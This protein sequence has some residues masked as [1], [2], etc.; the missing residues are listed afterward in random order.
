MGTADL[1]VC[2]CLCVKQTDK[3]TRGVCVHSV[4]SFN[5]CTCEYKT[6]KDRGQLALNSSVCVHAHTSV[7]ALYAS[8]HKK[9]CLLASWCPC[10]SP[11]LC[12]LCVCM[13]HTHVMTSEVEKSSV[14]SRP[15]RQSA[16]FLWRW[17]I[18]PPQLS[19]QRHMQ[20]KRPTIGNRTANSR[21]TAA[22]IRKPIS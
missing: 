4:F 3:M 11:Y 9:I 6:V 13:C 18:S 5:V 8:L 2:V 19:Q 22:H 15:R 14:P 21:P 12:H 10:V 17:C 16:F 7:H 20:K 1:T